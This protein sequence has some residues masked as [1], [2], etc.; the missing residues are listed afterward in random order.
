MREVLKSIPITRQQ[1]LKA[2][3]LFAHEEGTA[4][5]YSGGDFDS[6]KRSFL[7]LFPFETI[8]IHGQKVSKTGFAETHCRTGTLGILFAIGCRK[9]GSQSL[10]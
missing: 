1:L 6:A 7:F 9:E 4:L 10:S 5:L 3:S 2:A 8:C